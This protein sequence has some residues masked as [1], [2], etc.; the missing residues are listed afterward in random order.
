MYLCFDF[1]GMAITLNITVPILTSF[2]LVALITLAILCLKKNEI[3]KNEHIK[4]YACSVI[5][6]HK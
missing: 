3:G 6:N 5:Y 1:T 2:I 4:Q